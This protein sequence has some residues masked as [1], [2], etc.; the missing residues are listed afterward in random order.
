MLVS[1]NLFAMIFIFPKQTFCIHPKISKTKREFLF[2]F[3][4]SFQN[5]TSIKHPIK[6][7]LQSLEMIWPFILN[8]NFKISIFVYLNT[9][10]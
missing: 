4:F 2:I 6:L 1:Q 7:K 5:M 8:F 3:F 9:L 10:N